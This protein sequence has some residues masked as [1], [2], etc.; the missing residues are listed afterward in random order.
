MDDITPAFEVDGRMVRHLDV[1]DIPAI[2][3]AEERCADY[4]LLVEGR[5][6]QPDAG[7]HFLR[8]APDGWDPG[9]L[10]KLGVV[11]DDGEFVGLLD[12]VP[13]YP[14]AGIWYIGL[15]LLDPAVRGA[16]FGTRLYDAFERWAA[17][18][19]AARVMLTVIQEN[20]AAHR[21]WTRIG[22]RDVRDVPP[23]QFGNKMQGRWE[24]AKT[25]TATQAGWRDERE[26]R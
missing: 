13:G 23:R 22:F 20:E 26:G 4:T 18:Q 9:A 11:G 7:E 3:R 25:I 15:M 10:H 14:E 1:Q 6:P 19:G 16:G 17:S 5:G 12:I 8:D 24:M 2:Q 21:F